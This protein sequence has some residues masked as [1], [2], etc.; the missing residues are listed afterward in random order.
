MKKAVRII[1]AL[2]I[3]VTAVVTAFAQTDAE[4]EKALE[5]QYQKL[6]EAH[7]RKDLKA[8]ANLKTADF[9]AIFPNGKVGDVITM[10]QYTKTIY[11]E[12]SA[13][14]QYQEHD[15]KADGVSESTYRR[16]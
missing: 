5:L 2:I 11:R 9:H 13:A 16:G 8:I 14:I 7:D 3:T 4:I 10:Q 6:A 15:S 1:V 12:Q